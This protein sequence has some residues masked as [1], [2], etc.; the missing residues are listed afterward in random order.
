MSSWLRI[1][2]CGRSESSVPP[3]HRGDGAA[4]GAGALEPRARAEFTTEVYF[5]RHDVDHIPPVL[6]CA[7]DRRPAGGGGAGAAVMPEIE[8]ALTIQKTMVR[9]SE[10]DKI[11]NE[12]QRQ[13]RVSST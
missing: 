3:P 6:P 9:Q 2:G 7:A 4:V 11:F 8:E 1:S 10:F 12:A 5:W 13:G